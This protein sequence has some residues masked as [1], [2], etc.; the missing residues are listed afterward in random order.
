[1][2]FLV[3]GAKL[4]FLT[5]LIEVEIFLFYHVILYGLTQCLTMFFNVIVT[6]I[7]VVVLYLSI[8]IEKESL[9]VQSLTNEIHQVTEINGDNHDPTHEED[10]G[11]GHDPTYKEDDGG[12][13]ITITTDSFVTKKVTVGSKPNYNLVARE[14]SDIELV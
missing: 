11:D 5:Y 10:D 13:N 8:R 3:N 12:S 4:L 14:E 1:M 2:L 9:N 7:P 6:V